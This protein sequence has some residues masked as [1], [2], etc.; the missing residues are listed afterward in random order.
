MAEALSRHL[1]ADVIDASSAG[2]SPFG[3]IVDTTRRI[4]LERGVSL[5]DQ[6]SKGLRDVSPESA[7]LVV[8]MT[9]IPGVALFPRSRV[10]DWDIEDPYGED[11]AVYRRICDEIEERVIELATSLRN[12]QGRPTS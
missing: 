5:G 4:L 6:F 2:I 12:Q 9:G 1:A 8:N 11:M 7:T 3:R 10:M